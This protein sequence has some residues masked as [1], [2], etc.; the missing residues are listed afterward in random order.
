MTD[1]FN[2]DWKF[3]E[4]LRPAIDAVYRQVFPSLAR[5]TTVSRPHGEPHV[6]DKQLGI[7][8]YIILG[9]GCPVTVQEKVRRN[10]ALRFLDFTQEYHNAAGTRHEAK[11]EWFK[12]SAQLYFYGWA[13]ADETALADWFMLDVL[14][15]KLLVERR[16]G[17]AK[18]GTLRTNAAH[19]SATFYT[20]PIAELSPAILKRKPREARPW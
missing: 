13:T 5:V 15:Y 17:L 11:G 7:D 19:G 8:C 6:L 3:M 9:S 4:R 14:Q 1:Q 12:L 18:I 10:S 20:I 16:G 2:N